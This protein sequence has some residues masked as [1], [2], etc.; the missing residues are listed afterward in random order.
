MDAVEQATINLMHALGNYVLIIGE[1]RKS[2][3]RPGKPFM[4]LAEIGQYSM[5]REP[6]V[7]AAL[8]ALRRARAL[9]TMKEYADNEPEECHTAS[10]YC[11]CEECQNNKD[12]HTYHMGLD[13]D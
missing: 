12:D 4:S 5:N 11:R 7:R 1:A 10:R 6:E 9:A 2:R 3:E 8:D 13:N